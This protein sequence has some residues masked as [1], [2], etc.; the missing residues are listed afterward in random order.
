MVRSKLTLIAVALLVAIATVQVSVVEAN[1]IFFRPEWKMWLPEQFYA[2]TYQTSTVPIEIQIYIPTDYPKIN[3]MYYI[4]DLNYSSNNNL[5][6]PLIISEAQSSSIFGEPAY[7]YTATGTTD[8]L[9][10]GTHTLD[11]YAVNAQGETAKSGT[12]TFLVN[13]TSIA[14]SAQP[15]LLNNVTIVIVIAITAI[16][17]TITLFL[18]M[19]KKNKKLASKQG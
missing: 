1:P 4:L 3:K 2:K 15:S 5:Q 13:A 12:R 18:L 9:S 8:T 10:N 7:L 17:G 14:E 11:V 19:K 16:V 6:K